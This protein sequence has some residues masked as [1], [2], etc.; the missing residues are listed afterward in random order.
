MNVT[1]LLGAGASANVISPINGLAEGMEA[2][3]KSLKRDSSFDE[4]EKAERLAYREATSSLSRNLSWLSKE[5]VRYGSVDTFAKVLHLKNDGD[6]LKKLKA[7]LQAFL[8]YS[9]LGNK[10]DSR[11]YS[12]FASILRLGEKRLEFPP[13]IKVLTWNYDNQSE[14]ALDELSISGRKMICYKKLS[15]KVDPNNYFMYKLNGT[16]F[17][18]KQ[19]EPVEYLVD[20][21]TTA[22]LENLQKLGQRYIDLVKGGF[23]FTSGI[24]FS[25]ELDSVYGKAVAGTGGTEVLVIVGYS[26]PFFNREIDK[27]L[28]TNMKHLQKIYIQDPNAELIESRILPYVHEIVT[29]QSVPKDERQFYLPDELE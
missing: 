28:L 20:V 7:T 1:Y 2:M 3:S 19:D 21:N 15:P 25:W 9:Q 4:D 8:N 5:S 12:F 13:A 29:I 24:S 16:S 27:L 23:G 6:E 11:Y 14:M 26:F 18:L 22:T 17:T 10:V